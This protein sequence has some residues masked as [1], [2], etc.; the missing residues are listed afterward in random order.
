MRREAKKQI[1]NLHE[2][3]NNAIKFVKLIKKEGKD[4][5]R[6]RCMRNRDGRSGFSK[7][8]RRKMWKD[9]MEKI[10]NEENEWD[11]T[12]LG[13]LEGI[14]V[15][16]EICKRMLNGRGMAIDWKMDAR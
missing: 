5:E 6:G 11:Q 4:V 14:M 16:M 1:E 3:A 2:K 9:F 15:I 7:N 12:E 8:D 10:V 13:V